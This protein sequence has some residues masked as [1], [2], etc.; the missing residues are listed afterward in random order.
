MK[1]IVY[2]LPLLATVFLATACDDDDYREPSAIVDN[3]IE[4]H[5]KL[6]TSSEYGWRLDYYPNQEN[7]AFSFLMKFREDGRVEMLT[8]EYFFR[9]FEEDKD[10]VYKAQES[11]YTIQNSQGPV[12]T[13]ATYSLLTKLAD[14]ELFNNGSGWMGENEFVLMGH[15]QTGDTIYLKSLKAQ[16]RLL[17]VKNDQD[18]DEYFSS[19]NAVIHDFEGENIANT[20]FRDIVIG[21]DIAVLAGVNMTSRMGIIYQNRDNRLV[22]DS[23]RFSFTAEGI[24]LDKPVKIGKT[25]VHHFTHSES[26]VFYVNGDESGTLKVAENGRPL[27]RFSVRDNLFVGTID[28][29]L[30]GLEMSKTDLYFINS[31]P[32]TSDEQW[33]K[34]YDALESYLY[35]VL[36]PDENKNYYVDLYDQRISA[37]GQSNVVL[38]RKGFSY[39]WSKTEPDEITFRGVANEMSV[40]GTDSETGDYESFTPLATE[41]GK[42]VSKPYTDYLTSLFGTSRN[43]VET[44]VVPS[45]DNKYFYFVNKANGTVLSI[46]KID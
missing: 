36:I 31:N 2:I 41:F 20:Y 42:I 6:L 40:L 15:N 27:M 30:D 44:V 39:Q 46:M 3:Y 11:D 37:N 4:E 14:P 1:K 28:Y 26:G 13:F 12:L 35:M 5:R 34:L 16:R 18:W 45:P 29:T 7:G 10:K 8:D 17:L 43:R 19:I 9:L 25:L 22:A 38:A 33:E 32:E 24:S 23:C 21:T